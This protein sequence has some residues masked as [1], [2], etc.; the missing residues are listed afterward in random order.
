[1]P[2]PPRRR[3]ASMIIPGLEGG[4]GLFPQV[5]GPETLGRRDRSVSSLLRVC[6]DIGCV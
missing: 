3:K 6:A 4:M 5:Q 2:G 1:M